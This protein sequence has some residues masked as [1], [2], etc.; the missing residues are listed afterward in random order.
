MTVGSAKLAAPSNSASRISPTTSRRS[1]TKGSNPA[2][3]TNSWPRSSRSPRCC[4]PPSLGRRPRRQRRSTREALQS[5][6][7]FLQDLDALAEREAHEVPAA[8]SVG[9]EHLAG[10]RDDTAALG[11]RAAEGVTVVFTQWAD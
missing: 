8:L 11:Q 1:P 6:D 2:S 10:D 7:R 4:S 9:V 5:F 3:W